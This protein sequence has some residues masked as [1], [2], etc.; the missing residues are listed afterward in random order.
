MKIQQLAIKAMLTSKGSVTLLL[1]VTFLIVFS[2]NSSGLGT[3]QTA[4]TISGKVI[5]GPTALR[6]RQGGDLVVSLEGNV[7]PR[8]APRGAIIDEELKRVSLRAQV[9]S[10]G[11]FTFSNVPAGRY[12]LMTYVEGA[13]QQSVPTVVV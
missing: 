13:E 4:F 8:P 7:A 1:L 6:A 5:G 9:A 12:R 3:Q 2:L 11:S 10:D